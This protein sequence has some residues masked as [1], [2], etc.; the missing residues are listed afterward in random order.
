MPPS[1]A[2]GL[3]ALVQGVR[4]LCLPGLACSDAATLPATPWQVKLDTGLGI[5]SGV[6]PSRWKPSAP[7]GLPRR[8]KRQ[9]CP[10]PHGQFVCLFFCSGSVGRSARRASGRC[11]IEACRWSVLRASPRD[12]ARAIALAESCWPFAVL[13]EAN[14]I[15]TAHHCSKN[16]NSLLAMR[17]WAGVIGNQ[18]RSS[19][20]GRGVT[21]DGGGHG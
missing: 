2:E 15:I 6:G 7:L 18:G 3:S 9:S 12:S 14:K 5:K 13:S 19:Q 10:L 8:P 11:S 4:V 1:S 21:L 17:A 20:G 16:Q